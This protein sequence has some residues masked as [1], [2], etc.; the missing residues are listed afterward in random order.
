VKL[1]PEFSILLPPELVALEWLEVDKVETLEE[2]VQAF[3]GTHRV[4]DAGGATTEGELVIAQ[5]TR[6][7]IGG[8][9]LGS[10]GELGVVTLE[11]GKEPRTRVAMVILFTAWKDT[12]DPLRE[13]L[14]G[15]Q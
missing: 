14:E 8:V 15:R 6:I 7:G 1:Q 5:R 4:I 11:A 13:H 9:A 10:H 12:R 3:D 2:L